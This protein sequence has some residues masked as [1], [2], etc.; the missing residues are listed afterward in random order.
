MT[1][2]QV[3]KHLMPLAYCAAGVILII[4][5]L[6]IAARTALSTFVEA[7]LEHE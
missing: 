4:G 1:R 7:L 3:G 5:I 6:G 2:Q